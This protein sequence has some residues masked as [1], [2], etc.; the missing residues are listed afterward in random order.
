[1]RKAECRVQIAK[2][3]VHS[4]GQKF[5]TEVHILVKTQFTV[6]NNNCTILVYPEYQ[7]LHT[8]QITKRKLPQHTKH[9]TLN[10][11][12]A[13]VGTENIK[14]RLTQTVFTKLKPLS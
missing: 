10:T 6:Q 3:T 8:L 2:F 1:M 13:G 4:T 7:A 14:E 5:Y 11:Y 9:S 12:T